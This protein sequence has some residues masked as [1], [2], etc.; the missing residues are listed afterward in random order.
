MFLFMFGDLKY[1][2]IAFLLD[3]G[4]GWIFATKVG[5]Y[6]KGFEFKIGYAM[7]NLYYNNTNNVYHMFGEGN[8]V[9][10]DLGYKFNWAPKP[11]QVKEETKIETKNET[12]VET[13]PENKIE[14]LKEAKQG[15]V[16]TFSDIIFYPDLDTIKETSYPVLDQ[17]AEVLNDRKEISINIEGYTNSTGDPRA[18]LLLSEKR[19]MKVAMYL[20][21]KGV[22]AS[23]IKTSGNGALKLKQATIDEANRRV[24]IKILKTE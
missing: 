10:L 5:L 23:R 6:I 11:K 7:T 14:E 22:V 20:I 21:K 13:K 8:N 3:L 16:V 15:D 4:G 19:A 17:I 12:V 18:E 1:K 9:T 24:E 2:K